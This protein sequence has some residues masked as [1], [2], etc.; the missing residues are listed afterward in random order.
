M[1]SVIVSVND[2]NCFNTMLRPS[3]QDASNMVVKHGFPPLDIIIVTGNFSIFHNYNQGASR[4]KFPIKV[5]IHQDVCLLDTSW[6]FKIIG[7]FYMYPSCG[8]IGFVGTTKLLNRGMWWESGVEYIHGELFSG[9]EKAN[10][11]FKSISEPIKVEC[12]DGFFLAT[13]RNIMW[14]TTLD[15]FHLYDLDYCREIKKAGYDIMVVPHKVWHIGE[16]REEKP[17]F[18][19]YYKKWNL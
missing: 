5:F 15:G 14:D 12:V 11:V 10:W 16:I 8:L 1:F 13:N 19:S 6:I 9:K 17:V 2:E 4:S 7:S 18:D 3:L